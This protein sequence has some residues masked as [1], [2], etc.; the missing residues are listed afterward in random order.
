[1]L[2]ADLK[3]FVAV[4]DHGSITRAADALSLTQSAVSRRIQHLEQ[5]L[6]AVLFDR[7]A[8]PPAP[9]ALAHRLHAEAL[10][11]LGG[12]A[13]LFEMA[14]ED[15]APAGQFRLGLTQVVG[16]VVLF[17]VVTRLRAAFPALD[18]Q[19][20]TAWGAALQR[21]LAA[22][23]LDAAAVLLP[24]PGAPPAGMRGR[25]I[26]TLEVLVVQSRARPLVASRATLAALAEQAWILNPLGCGYRAALERALGA[27]GRPLKLGVD[28]AGTVL[29]LQLVAAG[30]GLG[31][32]PRH[33]LRHSALADA[34]SVVEV[35]GFAL[36]L[37][38]W[39]LQAAQ[40]GKLQRAA[41]LLADVVAE[42][43]APPAA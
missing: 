42:A 10:A 11:L 16:E 36:R 24:A 12:V 6:G 30:L 29:Q 4:M 15:A 28:T 32:V 26:D 38:L 33:A 40:M 3:A 17:D 27:L 1:M 41:D 43:Y 22:G 9:S 14:R 18:V 8:R 34:V 2:F 19:L 25:H 23:T 7:G 37:D 13:Q 21:Q 31:L 35:P 39:V 20:V 5:V